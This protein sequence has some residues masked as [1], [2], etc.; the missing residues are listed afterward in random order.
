M[1]TTAAE[2]GST[3]N[4]GQSQARRMN[5]CGSWAAETRQRR[6]RLLSSTDT[7]SLNTASA[8]RTTGAGGEQTDGET[9]TS[10]VHVARHAPFARGTTAS[11]PYPRATDG[12]PRTTETASHE[13]CAGRPVVS[14]P[15]SFGSMQSSPPE[16]TSRRDTLSLPPETHPTRN[17]KFEHVADAET[18]PADGPVTPSHDSSTDFSHSGSSTS[19]LDAATA[20][21][22]ARSDSAAA[23]SD[24]VF[25]SFIV[26]FLVAVAYAAEYTKIQVRTETNERTFPGRRILQGRFSRE[27]ILHVYLRNAVFCYT[28]AARKGTADGKEII[29]NEK[30][31][32]DC[33]SRNVHLNTMRGKRIRMATAP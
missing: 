20:G 6:G 1:T 7:S 27:R 19:G 3:E 14:S 28:F 33:I 30:I 5:S 13:T 15:R 22:A 32:P 2:E 4:S 17:V 25:M 24:N 21:C 8:V 12:T 10:N 9:A 26:M 23:A 18:P 31:N 29:E 11:D 16:Y